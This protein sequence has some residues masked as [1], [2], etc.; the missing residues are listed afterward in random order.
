MTEEV[1]P[2]GTPYGQAMAVLHDCA[3]SL[4]AAVVLLPDH[5]LWPCDR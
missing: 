3:D 1:K 4:P 5:V 2:K